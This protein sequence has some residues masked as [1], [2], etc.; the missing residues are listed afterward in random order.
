MWSWILIEVYNKIC[1]KN[2]SVES[3]NRYNLFINI[4]FKKVI[5]L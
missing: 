3:T 1:N 5:S 4:N 2:M